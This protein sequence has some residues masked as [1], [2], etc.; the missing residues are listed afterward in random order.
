VHLPFGIEVSVSNY[1]IGRIF[2]SYVWC[3]RCLGVFNTP[4][5]KNLEITNDRFGTDTQIGNLAV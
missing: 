3:F 2:F 5:L 4:T 1:G